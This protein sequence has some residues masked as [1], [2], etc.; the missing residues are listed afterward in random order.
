MKWCG[1]RIIKSNASPADCADRADRLINSKLNSRYLITTLDRYANV[2]LNVGG[3]KCILPFNR[4][5]SGVVIVEIFP[6]CHD[7]HV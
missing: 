3:N 7:T 4:L 1:R 2:Q 5:V 6:D